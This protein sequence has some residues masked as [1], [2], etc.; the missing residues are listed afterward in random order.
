MTGQLFLIHQGLAGVDKGAPVKPFHLRHDR[1]CACIDDNMLCPDDFF[2]FIRGN[3]DFMVIH[4]GRR[5]VIYSHSCLYQLVIIFP[6]KHGGETI[7]L[8]H[9]FCIPL[10]FFFPRTV[11]SMRQAGT[12]FQ[13]F[14]GYAGYIDAGAAIP[15]F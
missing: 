10:F 4:K 12:V 6:A 1:R 15:F 13:R 11:P 5:A 14:T 3:Q 8:L 2:F 7:L 9:R